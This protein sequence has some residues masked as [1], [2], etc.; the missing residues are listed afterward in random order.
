MDPIVET[1][2]GRLRGAREGDLAV[3]RGVPFAAAPVGERRFR[4]PEPAEPWPGVRDAARFGPS[5]PQLPV[6]FDLI[7][8]LDVGP[9]DEDC[10]FLNVFTP[11]PGGGRRPV[12]V[13][14]HGGAFTIGS[15][16]QAMYD[17]RPLARRG[18]VVVVT[19]NYR[20]GALGFLALEDGSAAPNAGLLDQLAALRFVGEN[21]AAFGGDPA[22]VTVFGESA[23]G[24]SVGCLLG[25]RE[26][27]GLFARAIPMSGA[28]HGANPPEVAARVRRDLCR[29]LGLAD[30]DLAGLRS[31][32]VDAIL[33]A[34][35]SCELSY[36]TE[37]IRMGFRPN[38]DGRALPVRPI[39]GIRAGHAAG[40]DVLAGATRDEWRLFGLMDPEAGRL[41]E[42]GLAARVE[43]RA[44]G[45]G[46][47]IVA[48]YRAARPEASPADLFFAVES[49]RLFRVPAI[50]LAEAQSAHRERT[51]SYLF[52]WESPLFG[53]RLGACHGVDVPFAFGLI[54]TPGAEKFA[55]GGPAARTLAERTMDAWL[56]FARRGEPGHPGLPAWPRFD[57]E[58]RAT[59]L[60]GESCTLEED[61]LGPERAAWDGVID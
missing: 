35:R 21:A 52:T 13:W 37:T 46:A 30:G 54:G 59:L 1:S 41:D 12:L 25:M 44:P 57:T 45:H 9:T 5:A 42:A 50:R 56:G 32:P 31:A 36:Q 3:F 38:V 55:G 34:Q 27:Q 11:G 17:P 8:G 19:L 33:K 51:F 49:D 24:M 2:L 40:V 47:R 60:F 61:P 6:P 58:T 16:S 15:G 23:G 26:S 7:P 4:A 29:E 48:A 22:N 14:I 18:D 28:A 10:L 39:D 43:A 53:G 20:L